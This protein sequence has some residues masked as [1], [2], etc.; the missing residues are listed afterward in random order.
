M[1]LRKAQMKERVLFNSRSR[2]FYAKL[3]MKLKN[4]NIVVK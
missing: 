2:K 1:E 3:S 4:H